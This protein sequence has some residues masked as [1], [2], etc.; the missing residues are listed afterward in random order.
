MRERIRRP[1]PAD[2]V[3]WKR[4][5][6]EA[7]RGNP[8]EPD[9]V[10]S[11]R[12]SVGPSRLVRREAARALL[13]ADGRFVLLMQIRHPDTGE[14]MLL[15]PGGGT[16]PG[17]A[18]RTCLRRELCEEVGLR[19]APLGP[20]VWRRTH[21]FGWQ[22]AQIS[23]RETYFYCPTELF[24][25]APR[26]PRRD[27]EGQCLLGCCWWLITDIGRSDHTVVPRRLGPLLVELVQEGPPDHLLA[28]GT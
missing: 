1:P 19:A 7:P 25:P 27:S 16:R 22:G 23:Q 14:V 13:V 10:G 2:A 5:S 17:E 4:E 11:A 15:T 28:A 20:A 9:P 26:M 21:T 8:V 18:L 12:T 24:R 3:G 6:S